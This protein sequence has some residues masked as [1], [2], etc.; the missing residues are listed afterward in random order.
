MRSSTRRIS[1]LLIC[2]L[3]LGITAGGLAAEPPPAAGALLERALAGPLADVEEIV[4]AVREFGTDPH[5]Y[6]NFGYWSSDPQKMMYGPDGGRLVK[7]NIRNGETEVLID[8]PRGSVRDVTVDYDGRTILFSYRRGGSRHF[9]LHEIRSDGT[10]LRQI[11]DGPYDDIEATYLPC[12]DIVFCSTRCH[13]WVSCWHTQVAVLYRADRDG[14]N[15]RPI[16]S[17]PEQDNTPAV[18]PDGR[19]LY[20]RWEY[21]DR[22]QVTFHH[23]WTANPDGTSQMVL[24]GNMHPGTVM[25]DAKAIPESDKLAVIF[26][27]GHGMTEHAGELTIVDPR[28]GPDVQPQA[29]AVKGAPRRV[30]DAFPL[31]EEWHLVARGPDLVLVDASA[32]RHEVIHSL[33]A[34]DRARRMQVN[35]PWPL[36]PRRREPLIPDRA[37][38]SSEKGILLLQNVRRGRNMDG[39]ESGEIR[40]LL[41]IETLPKPV[42]FSGGPDLVSWLGTFTLE[43]ILGTVPVEP[44]GSAA[45]ELPAHRPVFFVAL[46][47]DDLAVKRMQ[48][49]VSVMPGEV[50]S[51]VGCHEDRILTPEAGRDH[52]L[53]ALRRPPSRIEPID[54]VPEVIDFPRDVQP[55][56]DRRCVPCHDF[57]RSEGDVVLSGDRGLHF[58][59][60]YWTLLMRG[61]IADGRNAYGNRPP[62]SIGSSASRLMQKIDG[63][64]H[65]VELPE[66]E[67]RLIRLWLETGAV[68]AGTYAALGT[69]TVPAG[70]LLPAAYDVVA[71]RCQQC[72]ALPSS[73]DAGRKIPLAAAPASG[74]HYQRVVRE[75]E[76]AARFA[77]NCLFNFTRP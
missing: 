18:L 67:R 49:F 61:Q 77:V 72:H 43:R 56:L 55:V 13:R 38:P 31:S 54:G 57:D 3:M 64:H 42:N 45:I 12:G 41:V 25:I 35:E 63:S 65:E 30:R 40:K 75:D 17:N 8:D 51:C 52:V 28:A 11:T 66:A 7:L 14:G 53:L 60:S 22:N 27:P 32:G 5:W 71:R 58:S 70:G 39:V 21:I 19:I 34:A 2:A 15:L 10:G 69:S 6:A 20:T 16:S 33:P 48:S 37:D 46:D 29:R 47:E 36:R 24:F 74:A 73:P 59:H 68:Y 62:R 76:P 4:F 9:H 26:S 50:T 44:D 23:L 1:S